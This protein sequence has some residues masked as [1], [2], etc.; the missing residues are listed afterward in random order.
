VYAA[1]ILVR[2]L[3]VFTKSAAGK[4]KLAVYMRERAFNCNTKH[5]KVTRIFTTDIFKIPFKHSFRNMH[6]SLE[7][8]NS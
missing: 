4:E 7:S 8:V 1:V 6:G 5:K 3:G 2:V